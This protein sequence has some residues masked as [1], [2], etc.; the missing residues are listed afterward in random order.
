MRLV[1]VVCLWSFL[2]W[3][4]MVEVMFRDGT[5]RSLGKKFDGELIN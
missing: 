2:N 4:L 1:G 3:N 5:T